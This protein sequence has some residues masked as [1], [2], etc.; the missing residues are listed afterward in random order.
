LDYSNQHNIDRLGIFSAR[1]GTLTEWPLNRVTSLMSGGT[2]DFPA[3]R[4]EVWDMMQ[5][6]AAYT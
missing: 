4:Q 3:A 5:E 2:F 6:D 1:Y